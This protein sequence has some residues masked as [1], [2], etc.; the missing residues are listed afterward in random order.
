MNKASDVHTL[1]GETDDTQ[2]TALVC[3]HTTSKA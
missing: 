3:Y 2:L 1:S